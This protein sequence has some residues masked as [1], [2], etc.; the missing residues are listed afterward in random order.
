MSLWVDVDILEQIKALVHA[1]LQHSLGNGAAITWML[2]TVVANLSVLSERPVEPGPD[3]TSTEA[4]VSAPPAD[5]G[6]TPSVQSAPKQVVILVRPATLRGLSRQ[7]PGVPVADALYLLARDYRRLRAVVPSSQ[8]PTQRTLLPVRQ[9]LLR[10]ITEEVQHARGTLIDFPEALRWLLERGRAGADLLTHFDPR[11]EMSRL[12]RQSDW[13]RVTLPAELEIALRHDARQVTGQVLSFNQIILWL[14]LSWCQARRQPSRLDSPARANPLGVWLER[15]ASP[16]LMAYL[17]AQLH[18]SVEPHWMWPD[19]RAGALDEASV[20]GRP[21]S[22]WSVRRTLYVHHTGQSLTA[23]IALGPRCEQPE[24]VH[25]DH[26]EALSLSALRFDIGALES[27]VRLLHRKGFSANAIAW[28]TGMPVRRVK[29][30]NPEPPVPLDRALTLQEALLLSHSRGLLD[31]WSLGERPKRE[32]PVEPVSLERIWAALD[33][34]Y[35]GLSARE[36]LVLRGVFVESRSEQ[37]LS[38]DLGVTPGRVGCIK[39]AALGK[40]RRATS[41]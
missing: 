27:W 31:E 24:C 34:P 12:P 37:D 30:V 26:Q 1:D 21:L 16:D 39:S 14:Y 4:P 25:P 10:G 32:P 7:Y 17:L 29:H 15:S 36:K 38:L 18:R 5:N 11:L 8:T 33:Q 19:V 41:Q 9:D 2:N 6:L 35:S 20:F 3:T 40:V 22:T 13:A 23:H 28:I